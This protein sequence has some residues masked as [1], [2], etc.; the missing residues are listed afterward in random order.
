M[1]N[2]TSNNRTVNSKHL[3]GLGFEFKFDRWIKDDKYIIDTSLG[4]PAEHFK[5]I[6][7]RILEFGNFPSCDYKS[8]IAKEQMQPRYSDAMKY[9]YPGSCGTRR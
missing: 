1:K 7:N 6:V 4:L 3:K 2:K 5:K 9:R 8:I